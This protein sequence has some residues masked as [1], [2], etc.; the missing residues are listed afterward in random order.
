MIS[1]ET[2]RLSQDQRCKLAVEITDHHKDA[3]QRHPFKQFVDEIKS[4]LGITTDEDL[5]PD[6]ARWHRTKES[7]DP[8]LLLKLAVGLELTSTEE[9]E[10][11]RRMLALFYGW[12]DLNVPGLDRSHWE[13]QALFDK[14]SALPKRSIEEVERN[15]QTNLPAEEDK[16]PKAD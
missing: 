2:Q 6:Y 8:V 9:Q 4:E 1:A 10:R 14:V 15:L 11:A 16:R 12:T 13:R 5:E 3:R 7:D